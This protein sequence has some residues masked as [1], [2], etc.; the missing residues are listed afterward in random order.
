VK[1]TTHPSLVPRSKNAW[2][3][4]STP[5]ICLHGVVLSEA[6][7]QLYLYVLHNRI[8]STVSILVKTSGTVLKIKKQ[9]STHRNFPSKHIPVSILLCLE[10]KFSLMYPKVSVTVL[11]LY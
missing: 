3:Y 11:V 1:L 2:S 8:K 6:H 9:M 5:Q 4:T 10:T 7:G